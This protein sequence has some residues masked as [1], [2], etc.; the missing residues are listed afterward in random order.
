VFHCL[1]SDLV[2]EA[3]KHLD[4]VSF[5]SQGVASVSMSMQS[6]TDESV[7]PSRSV[8]PP[9]LLHHILH[10]CLQYYNAMS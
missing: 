8:P 2:S 7:D 1:A 3:H 5:H 6:V 4:T 9:L 10:D